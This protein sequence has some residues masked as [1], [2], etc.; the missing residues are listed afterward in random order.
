MY[1]SNRRKLSAGV[2]YVQSKLVK[3]CTV[4]TGVNVNRPNCIK[5]CTIQVGVNCVQA[6]LE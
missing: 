2:K 3:M 4:Q 6:K 1:S 5:I